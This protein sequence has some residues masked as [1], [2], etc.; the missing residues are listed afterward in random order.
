MAPVRLVVMLEWLT[1]ADDRT[2]ALEVAGEMAPWL[3]P[4]VVTVRTP[5]PDVAAAVVDICSRH[6]PVWAAA[7]RAIVAASVPARFHAHKIDSLLRG[8][9]AHELVAVQEA[10][11]GRVL[12][13]PAL[14]RL[15]RVC[16]GG[17]VYVH[18][19]PVGDHDARRATSSPPGRTP[20]ERRSGGRGR[21]RRRG[22]IAVLVQE[23][24]AVRS[25]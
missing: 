20:R 23:G 16:R 8:N 19:V 4:V 6:A 21:A 15:G 25:V 2:G 5:P 24:W 11:G 1:V 12:V 9:W 13:V 10:S 18:G 17:V 7:D 22:G 14:P 3:G